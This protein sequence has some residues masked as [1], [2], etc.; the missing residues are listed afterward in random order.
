MT[1]MPCEAACERGEAS[2]CTKQPN[3]ALTQRAVL[4]VA[5]V[6]RSLPSPSSRALALQRAT[7]ARSNSVLTRAARVPPQIQIG[8]EAQQ[9]RR[10][11]QQPAAV[12][13]CKY[14][15]Q[16]EDEAL[17]HVVWSGAHGKAKK[18]PPVRPTHA[19]KAAAHT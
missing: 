7:N 2:P 18:L 19:K 4:A 1:V 17:L 14:W 11:K 16:A 9:L 8:L 3:D 12:E 6:R 5:L 10:G 15:T 13:S